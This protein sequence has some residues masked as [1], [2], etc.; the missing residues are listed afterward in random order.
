M[1]A[2][3]LAAALA[4]VASGTDPA[5]LAALNEAKANL[6]TPEGAKY[7]AVFSHAFAAKHHDELMACLQGLTGSDLAPFDIVARV[8]ATGKLEVIRT[9]PRTK[10]ARC[11]E[12]KMTNDR[13][14]PPPKPL[15][16]VT[17]QMS[18]RE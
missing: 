3:L 14:P 17:V 15:W 16:W 11:I 9:E 6:K 7:D 8:G 1:R 12:P 2:A 10:V 4:F 5:F 18:I 13:Y